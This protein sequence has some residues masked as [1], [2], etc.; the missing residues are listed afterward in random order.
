MSGHILDQQATKFKDL[1]PQ[2]HEIKQ[3]Y[4]AKLWHQVGEDLAKYIDSPQ[5][6]E[7]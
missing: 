6:A 7:G 4:E 3:H 5:L 1:E 2:I